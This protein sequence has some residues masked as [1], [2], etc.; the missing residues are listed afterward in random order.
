MRSVKKNFG[1]FGCQLATFCRLVRGL[2]LK[3]PRIWFTATIQGTATE[4]ANRARVD[5]MPNCGRNRQSRWKAYQH[6]S[7]NTAAKG[8]H[9]HGPDRGVGHARLTSAAACSR[10]RAAL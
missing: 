9:G 3:R 2:A 8:I 10:Q 5:R 7:A 1:W 4:K 6:S